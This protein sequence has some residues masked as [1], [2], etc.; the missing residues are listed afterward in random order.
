MPTRQIIEQSRFKKHLKH[1]LQA[2]R[3]TQADYQQVLDYL[4]S[5]QPL[6]EKYD[7][8]VIKKRKTDRALFIKGNWLLIYRLE[9]D[10]VRLLD[11][12]RH[13]EV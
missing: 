13:G 6:P 10:V 12:G 4:R 7:D 9:T 5:G 11:V 3:F 8:H 1:L 2:G